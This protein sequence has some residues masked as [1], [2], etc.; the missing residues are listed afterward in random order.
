MTLYEDEYAFWDDIVGRYLLKV[1]STDHNLTHIIE[2]AG[3][4][5]DSMVLERRKRKRSKLPVAEVAAT[6]DAAASGA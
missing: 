6:R 5:A 1:A 4:Y 3:F 2:G